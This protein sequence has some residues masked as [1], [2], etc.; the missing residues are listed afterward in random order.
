MRR[1][2]FALILFCS[3]VAALSGT[4]WAEG[5]VTFQIEVIPGFTVSCPDTLTFAPIGPGQTTYQDLTVTIWSNVDWELSV[6]I[7]GENGG[8][9]GEAEFA[10]GDDVWIPLDN[11]GRSIFLNQPSTGPGGSEVIIPFR[12]TGSY[13]DTPGDYFFQVEFTVV[14]AL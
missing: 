13:Q 9:K 8:L 1:K 11:V 3:M 12:F 4:I 6:R 10:K 5:L 7:V 2:L 14:P